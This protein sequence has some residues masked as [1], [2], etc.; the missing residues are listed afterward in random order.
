MDVV[1]CC[2]GVA[3]IL[4]Y[5]QKSCGSG[6]KEL[7]AAYLENCSGRAYDV[8]ALTVHQHVHSNQVSLCRCVRSSLPTTDCYQ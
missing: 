2:R 6:F 8:E 1:V 7:P 5:T 4:Y 3:K